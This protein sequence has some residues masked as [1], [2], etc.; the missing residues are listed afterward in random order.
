MTL[1]VSR[2]GLHPLIMR[3]WPK[4]SLCACQSLPITESVARVISAM[5]KGRV[6]GVHSIGM[7]PVTLIHVAL[8]EL[9]VAKDPAC[10]A[11]AA[12]MPTIWVDAA[13]MTFGA[14][15]KAACRVDWPCGAVDGFSLCV[16]IIARPGVREAETLTRV[17]TARLPL[18][19]DG[20]S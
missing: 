1:L 9:L 4:H 2:A 18:C 14:S 8:P 20:C 11:D 13:P 10:A 17:S 16:A 12:G 3:S 7:A 19:F 15:A 6:N 5:Q